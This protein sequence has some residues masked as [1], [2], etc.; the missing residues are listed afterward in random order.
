M[1]GASIFMSRAF[2]PKTWKDDHTE[3]TRRCVAVLFI[4]TLRDG[5]LLM[6]AAWSTQ[7]DGAISLL[8]SRSAKRYVSGH[9]ATAVHR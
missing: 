7:G 6:P 1:S 2:H 9:N 8:L 4:N 5:E 3:G